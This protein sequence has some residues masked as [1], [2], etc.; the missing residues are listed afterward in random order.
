MGV[1]PP[2]LG[3]GARPRRLHLTYSHCAPAEVN[4]R[5]N[6]GRHAGGG[7]ATVNRPLNR[8]ASCGDR[9]SNW[10]GRPTGK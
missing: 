6:C 7:M 4:D 8:L 9:M 1:G 10:G 5:Q 3:N 2:E